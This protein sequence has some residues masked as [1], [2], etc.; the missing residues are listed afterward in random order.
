[1]SASSGPAPAAEWRLTSSP[2]PVSTSPYSKPV[3]RG[4]TR[5]TPRCSS[6]RTNRRAAAPPRPPSRS[7]NSTAASGDGS[8]RASRTPWPMGTASAG[9]AHAWSVGGRITG[10]GSRFALGRAISGQKRT[11]A[12]ETTGRSVTRTFG[13]TTTSS[14]NWSA[15][16]GARK[17]SPT[18]PTVC[19]CPP[20]SRDATSSWCS[21][22]RAG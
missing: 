3:G 18:R 21:R 13:R 2:V 16:S 17:T 12:S 1:M 14:S 19:S 15:C 4:T 9:G 6:G 5:P 20:P 10:G 22:R 11:T 7:G 8:S